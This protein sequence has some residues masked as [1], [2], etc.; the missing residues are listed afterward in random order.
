MDYCAACHGDNGE[1]GGVLPDLRWSGAIRNADAFYRV[2]GDGALTA[3]GMV[4][5]KK[6][7]SAAHI[8]SIRQFLIQRANATYQREVDARKNPQQ[9]PGQVIIGP[10][11]MPEK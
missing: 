8:E 4:G 1:S 3:Y 5:F 9:I 10:N 6:N 11:F 7:L 2:V